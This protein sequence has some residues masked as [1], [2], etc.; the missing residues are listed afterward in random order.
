MEGT[1]CFWSSLEILI[2]ITFLQSDLSHIFLAKAPLLLLELTQ[3]SFFLKSPMH[4]ALGKTISSNCLPLQPPEAA[5]PAETNKKPAK[6]TQRDLCI[7]ISP[8]SFEKPW[9]LELVHNF[10]SVTGYKTNLY[11]SNVFLYISNKQYENKL[12]KQ[13]NLQ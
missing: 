11:K 7:E 2:H 5:M 6:N 1:S 9:L 10:S 12:N 3:S 4:R 13:L 8:E